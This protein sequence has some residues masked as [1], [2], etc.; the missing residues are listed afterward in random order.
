[1]RTASLCYVIL[2]VSYI[3]YF[4]DLHFFPSTLRRPITYRPPL[5]LCNPAA[6]E[7]PNCFEIN[8]LS[9]TPNTLPVSSGRRHNFL[10]KKK[11]S[12]CRMLIDQERMFVCNY[13]V[14]RT[15]RNIFTRVP[16]VV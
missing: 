3:V 15:G 16:L 6:H 14:L 7:S 12:S 1:M 8:P 4:K 9:P 2:K 13:S 5:P 11:M 10:V